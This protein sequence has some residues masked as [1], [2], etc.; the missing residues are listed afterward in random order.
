MVRTVT[1]SWNCKQ[2]LNFLP[3]SSLPCQCSA[4][5]ALP[6]H[7]HSSAF[8]PHLFSPHLH[9][10]TCQ[11]QENV[12]TENCKLKPDIF[13]PRVELFPR[14]IK[15]IAKTKCGWTE[16]SATISNTTLRGKLRFGCQVIPTFHQTWH[17]ETGRGRDRYPELVQCCSFRFLLFN[18]DCILCA[19]TFT[20]IVADLSR[21][22]QKRSSR[23][24][25][26]RVC[27]E[28][29]FLRPA[30]VPFQNW[31]RLSLSPRQA[32]REG[33]SAPSM[34]WAAPLWS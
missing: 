15:P 16:D 12:G 2:D 18:F 20:E 3:L 4:S 25:W 23:W 17:W 11:D 29:P 5:S 8:P 28:L 27:A 14:Q 13:R 19:L 24:K 21:R 26:Y 34:A 7:P 32:P 10:W 6:P 31:T 22:W 1:I 9:C 33:R 30:F